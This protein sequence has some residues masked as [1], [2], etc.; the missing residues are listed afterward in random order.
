MVSWPVREPSGQVTSRV[1]DLYGIVE[2]EA[3]RG[4]LAAR[5]G[6]AYR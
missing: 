4:E 1:Q 6:G 2:G 5:L 3:V